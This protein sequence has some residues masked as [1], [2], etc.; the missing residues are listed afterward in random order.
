MD[1]EILFLAHRL[2]FPPDRGDKIRSHHVLKEMARIAPV[3]V[4]CLAES[5]A[6]VANS[7]FL[8]DIARS[9]CMPR[10]S[11]PVAIAGAQA[12]LRNEP[13]SLA[14]FR[15][16][17]LMEWTRNLLR[18]GRIGA[19]YV[20]S[21]QMGQYVPTNWRGR[22]VI[23]LVDV[24]SAKF[25]AYGQVR[26]GP[27][28]WIDT[29]EGRLLKAEE[30]RL[31]AK[32]DATLLV[33][34]AEANL[35]RDRVAGNH[36][37]RALRNGIDC[38]Y[39]DPHVVHSETALLEGGPHYV[40][41][42][43]MDYAPNVEAVSR[44]ARKIMPL[45]RRRLPGA[46]FHIVG[47]APSKEVRSLN[48]LH[49]TCVVG[50]VSD[51]RPWLAAADAVVAPLQIAR[52]VQ[53][54]V[55][56][57]MAMARPVVASFD[58]ANGI[59]ATDGQHILVAKSDADFVTTLSRIAEEPAKAERMGMAARRFVVETMSWTAMLADLPELLGFA[60]ETSRDAA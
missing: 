53:N 30:A 44:M 52:G 40:F 37:I 2:P 38:E 46:Q 16:C 5:E 33:S 41:T 49:G 14:A 8:D 36:A 34:E 56:E 27:R 13:V 35:L 60:A 21:G 42:G 58:A 24:D 26:T 57:A 25:E 7:H 32:A 18:T 3:H 19:I 9:W 28:A 22:L 39:F 10:R 47:R 6:D 31:A 15:S 45:V 1:G 51:T 59:D 4:G 55:L 48:G 12:L 11:K 50:E 29:R 54:K 43:Q 20:F 23:D 17:H